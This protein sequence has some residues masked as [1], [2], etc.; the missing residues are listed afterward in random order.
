MTTLRTPRPRGAPRGNLNAFKY[1]AHSPKYMTLLRVLLRIP[2]V[3]E[4]I[5]LEAARRSRLPPAVKRRIRALQ[6]AYIRKFMIPG[7][8][9][10]GTNT[11]NP[12]R[13][14]RKA[15]RKTQNNSNPRL[16]SSPSPRAEREI[17][18]VR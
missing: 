1:G 9:I 13:Q 11:R 4:I 15:P 12:S 16:P 2:L 14:V 3:R 17:Q 18:R 8:D 5:L 7:G 6:R 10:T